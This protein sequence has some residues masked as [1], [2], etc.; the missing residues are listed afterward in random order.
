MT[1]QPR[2][3]SGG[4]VVLTVE[5]IAK[6]VCRVDGIYPAF[7]RFTE[8]SR[9]TA[10]YLDRS[11]G[12]FYVKPLSEP[13]QSHLRGMEYGITLPFFLETHVLNINLILGW[14]DERLQEIALSH[15]RSPA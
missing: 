10:L 4:Y 1:D 15:L 2:Y 8:V 14:A 13:N 6:A 9:E 11:T 3:Q 7:I 5:K 12:R